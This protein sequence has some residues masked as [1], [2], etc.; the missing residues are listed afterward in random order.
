MY[1]LK[2]YM[3]LKL[4]NY[5]LYTKLYSFSNVNICLSSAP[6]DMELRPVSSY[7]YADVMNIICIYIRY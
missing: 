6:G 2:K 7:D 5:N 1:A 4:N 3:M